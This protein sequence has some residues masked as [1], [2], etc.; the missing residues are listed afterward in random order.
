[1]Y[2]CRPAFLRGEKIRPGSPSI[3]KD[4]ERELAPIVMMCITEMITVLIVG[5]K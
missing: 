1:M 2:Q 3:L 5:E 4:Y